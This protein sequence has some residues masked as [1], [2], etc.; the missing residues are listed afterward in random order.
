MSKEGK[1]QETGSIE[2]EAIKRRPTDTV[3]SKRREEPRRRISV[4]DNMNWTSQETNA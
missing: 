3:V 1:W 2:V 4:K